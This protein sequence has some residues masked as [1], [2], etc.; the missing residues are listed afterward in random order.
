MGLNALEAGFNEHLGKLPP[1]QLGRRHIF[2]QFGMDFYE[3][4]KLLPEQTVIS[5]MLVLRATYPAIRRPYLSC[6]RT[7]KRLMTRPRGFVLLNYRMLAAPRPFEAVDS[8][9]TSHRKT[10]VGA[11]DL[12]RLW[13]PD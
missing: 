4:R 1:G 7:C 10:R 13:V 2:V 5:R 9:R 3:C 11:G 8:A 6:R 12:K